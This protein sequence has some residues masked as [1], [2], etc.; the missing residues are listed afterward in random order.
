VQTDSENDWPLMTVF[1]VAMAGAMISLVTGSLFHKAIGY[2]AKLIVPCKV[3]L[4]HTSGF[5]VH[6]FLTECEVNR[7]ELA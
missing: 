3:Q 7:E 5:E 2:E 6:E 4:A 1:I